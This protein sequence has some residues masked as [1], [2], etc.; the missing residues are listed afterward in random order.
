M[1]PTGTLRPAHTELAAVRVRRAEM[2]ERL[3]EVENALAAPASGQEVMWGNAVHAAL[4]L[5]EADFAAHIEVTEGPGGLHESI[6]DG[7][8]RLANAVD[9]LTGEHAEIRTRLRALVADSAPPVYS[10]DV[11]QLRERATT[12]L[13]RLARHR[14]RGAD[15]VYEAFHTDVGGGD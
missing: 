4:L 9:V 1:E 2:R 13:A 6:L 8:L 12:L 15:L 10:G 5:L 7:D 11:D 3:G 14:Q